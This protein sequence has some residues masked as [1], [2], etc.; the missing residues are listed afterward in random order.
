MDGMPAHAG[1]DARDDPPEA[2]SEATF[3]AAPGT[4]DAGR[5]R[6][7]SAALGYTPRRL[8][9]VYLAAPPSATWRIQPKEI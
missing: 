3:G 9:P 5:S 6:K 7:A 4:I 8:Q 1:Q 2:T